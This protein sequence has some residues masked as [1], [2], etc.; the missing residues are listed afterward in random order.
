MK[1]I[2]GSSNPNL[3]RHLSD[4]MGAPIAEAEIRRFPD[5][6]L[7]ARIVDDI[8]GEDVCV[9][10]STYPDH[11]AVE[12][13]ILTRLARDLGAGSVTG[14]IPYYGYARQDRV[15]KEG[16]SFTARTMARHIQL[17]CDRVV[18]VN[19]HKEA[20]TREF[21]DERCLHVSVMPQIG[22]F[23][24]QHDIR[25]VLAP[26]KG[27]VEYARQAAEAAGCDYTNL[28]KKRLDGRTVSMAPKD[29]DVE[30]KRVCIIDDIIATG[31]TIMRASQALKDQG[32]GSV[33]ACCAH[34]LFTG[35]GLERLEPYLDGLYSTDTIEN[36]T[37]RISAAEAIAG[38]LL[39]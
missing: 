32:A 15:F 20:I 18:C 6:E 10:Q 27:A 1:L 29:L 21:T 13:L 4:I 16:E 33:F 30:G 2:S 22:E 8:S 11:N 28:E 26:D 12:F 14:V 34:G 17:S 3:S 31:G 5:G 9:V 7:Y 37:S 24:K 35:G 38:A 36:P 19:L 23:M 39:K 25:Y